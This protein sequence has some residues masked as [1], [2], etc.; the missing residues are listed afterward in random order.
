MIPVVLVVV[1]A[2]GLMVRRRRLRRGS[3]VDDRREL[4]MVAIHVARS[5]RQGASLPLALEQA[6]GR[7]QGPVGDALE[8]ASGSMRRGVDVD[9]ALAQLCPG[10]HGQPRRLARRGDTPLSLF[11]TAARF[12]FATG[13]DVAAALEGVAKTLLDR[14]ELAEETAALVSQAQTSAVVLCALPVVGLAVFGA[15]DPATAGELVTTPEGL[16]CLGVAAG[17]D[18]CAWVVSRRLVDRAVA[19]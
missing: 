15:M 14:A 6:A 8:R 18:L 13:G 4:A 16:I 1:A 7:H 11:G 10:R 17:L 2:V 19:E 3:V 5:M 9:E 12:G